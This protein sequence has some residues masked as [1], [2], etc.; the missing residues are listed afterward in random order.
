MKKELLS[1]NTLDLCRRLRG[2][3]TNAEKKLWKFLRNSQLNGFKFRRQYPVGPYVLDFFCFSKQIGIE[4]DGGGHADPTQKNHDEKR[5]TF[6]EEE[7]IRVLR[8]WNND[9]LDNTEGVLEAIL[10]AFQETASAEKEFR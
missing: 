4:L 1:K 3:S 7:G 8:F 2:S 6:L 5:T 9:V 10:I